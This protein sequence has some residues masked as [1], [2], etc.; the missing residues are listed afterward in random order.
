MAH[1]AHRRTGFLLGFPLVLLGL[2]GAGLVYREKM[3]DPPRPAPLTVPDRGR[4]PLSLDGIAARET[5]S[6]P[7]ARITYQQIPPRRNAPLELVVE[8]G[9]RGRMIAADPYTGE[10]LGR[11]GGRGRCTAGWVWRRRVRCR[12]PPFPGPC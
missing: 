7:G 5:A 6:M 12:W 1:G 4:A 9:G 2:S 3:E 8:A 10:V 11:P